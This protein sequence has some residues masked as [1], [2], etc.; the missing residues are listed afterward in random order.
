MSWWTNSGSNS[1]VWICSMEYSIV[2]P[3]PIFCILQ[4][5]CLKLPSLRDIREEKCVLFWKYVL[6]MHK[7]RFNQPCLPGETVFLLNI[8]TFSIH[9]NW[10][11]LSC[12]MLG[13]GCGMRVGQ[14][15]KC[16][17]FLISECTKIEIFEKRIA[18]ETYLY[19]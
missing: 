18:G 19:F 13:C 15:Q 12:G 5:W 17:H 16:K 6:R 2:E 9:D 4:L 7:K 8:F 14:N 1:V 11:H 10:I 3:L